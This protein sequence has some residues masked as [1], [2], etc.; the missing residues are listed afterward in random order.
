MRFFDYFRVAFKN[1]SRQK[2]RTA[3]TIVAITIGSISIILMASLLTTIRSSIYGFFEDMDAFTLVTV[4]ADPDSAESNNSLFNNNGTGNSEKILDDKILAGLKTLSNVA[5]ATPIGSGMWIK[6]MVLEGQTKKMWANLL[7]FDPETK[8]FNMPILAGRSLTADDMDKVIVSTEFAKTYGY[9]KNPEELIG[10]NLVLL[11]E[12]GNYPDWGGLIPEKPPDANNKEWWEEQQKKNIEIKAEIIG[13]AKSSAFSSGQNYINIAWAKKLMTQVYWEW[14]NT[15]SEEEMKNSYK[16][17]DCKS[18]QALAKQDNFAKNGYGSIILK[19]N[20]MNN[21]KGVADAVTKLGY[22]VTTAQDML[23]EI[24][25]MLLAIGTV[26][27]IIGGISLFVA[28]IGIINTMVMA[29]YE[30]TKEIGVMRACG[31]T[32]SAIRRL[33]TFE[34]ALLGLL[35]G[36]FG[37]ILSYGIGKFG[38]Y[39]AI[40]FISSVDLPFEKVASFPW[41]LIVGVLAFTTLIGLFSG[42]GPAVKAARLNPVDALR[43]E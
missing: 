32:R 19:A 27:G 25:K 24:N 15:C 30:R 1:L 12:G 31:A 17:Y 16:D 2:M 3:L 5:D 28:A 20:D 41:W 6:N 35:G 22:G 37:L 9:D 29:T 10:K 36:I 13:I 8:V 11:F 4:Y 21:I 26:L 43:Y 7:A 39:I 42:L 40:N 14:Q 23:D 18:T 34:A 38:N 33:F